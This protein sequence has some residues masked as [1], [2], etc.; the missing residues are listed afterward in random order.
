MIQKTKIHSGNWHVKV[1]NEPYS[2]VIVYQLNL[3]L[4][5]NIIILTRE[6]FPIGH[7]PTNR[8]LSYSVPIVELGHRIKVICLKPTEVI[9]Q[10]I[11][12]KD[13]SGEFEGVLYEYS[14]ETT[15][16]PKSGELRIKKFFLI[17]KGNLRAIKLLYKEQKQ[18]PLDCIL[19]YSNS[20]FS[21]ILFYIIA[22]ILHVKYVQEK[23]EYPYVLK[24]QSVLGRIFA[25]LYVN[26]AYKLCDGMLIETNTLISYYKSKIGKKTK[27]FKVPMTVNTGRFRQKSKN[28]IGEK[29]IAYCGN[30]SEEE[31]IDILIS[32]FN[33]VSMKFPDV[34]L[35][36]IG[37]PSNLNLFENYKKQV[38]ELNLT[39]HVLFTGRVSSNKV[40][41]Y[42]CNA[43]ILA[44][45]RRKSK[46]A[47]ASIPSKL[48]EYLSTSNPVVITS[49]GEITDY[50]EDGK[51]VFF[52]EPND[53][54]S[55]ANKLDFAL[56]NPEIAKEV[57]C[58]GKDI[59]TTYFDSKT[60]ANRI[61]NFLSELNR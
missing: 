18:R 51:N 23:N 4:F 2:G 12:N 52:A 42:L 13:V 45:A 31:G 5:M 55:F 9:T 41:E 17:L 21:I 24:N 33:Q 53:V 48:G 47:E 61:I 49:N 20:F 28:E 58:Q 50:L 25:F 43:T 60:Q 57:G 54:N 29:Y 14:P 26:I 6:P 10:A 16:W 35:V 59:A 27:I 30:M 44:L 19:L 56:S 40:P 36:L 11:N 22:K 1:S 34:K 46:Q 3:S 8:I 37:A 38:E 32:A 7:A 39:K 15:L